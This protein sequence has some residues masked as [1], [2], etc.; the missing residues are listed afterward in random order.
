MKKTKK[1]NRNFK[2]YG[3]LQDNKKQKLVFV[4]VASTGSK[5]TA[6][7]K[8]RLVTEKTEKAIRISVK[9]TENKDTVQKIR[10]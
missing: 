7:H 1:Q 3:Q 10:C 2:L 8:R 6:S 5:S 9:S 4:N